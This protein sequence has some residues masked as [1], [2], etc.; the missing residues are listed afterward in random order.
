[1]KID[2]CGD[3]D[4]VEGHTNMSRFLNA[5]GRHISYMMCRGP[6]QQMDKWGYA[7]G[8]AQGWRATGGRHSIA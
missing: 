3:H 2:Y 8:I 6:Y 4:S 7:P 5:T 1:M